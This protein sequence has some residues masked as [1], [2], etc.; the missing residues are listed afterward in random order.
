MKT[1]R[2]FWFG[3]VFLIGFGGLWTYF[4]WIPNMFP[5][6]LSVILTILLGALMG[7]ASWVFFT[8]VV[9]PEHKA[10]KARRR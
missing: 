10:G 5:F 6:L 9:I 4:A 8:N 3:Y 7:I 2:D 1:L